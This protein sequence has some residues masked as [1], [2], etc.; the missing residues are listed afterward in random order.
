MLERFGLE[1]KILAINADN[2]SSNK[3]QTEA[4]EK[5]KNSFNI[6]NRVRCF[7]HTI[8]LACKA[9]L[10]P[11]TA[12]TIT[13]DDDDDD[14]SSDGLPDLEDVSNDEDEDEEDSGEGFD[15]EGDCGLDELTQ[16]SEDKQRK[17]LDETAAVKQSL[18]KVSQPIYAI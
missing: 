14:T 7:N 15:H 3:T 6:V 10:H 2:A 1:N 8:Q 4:L 5:K 9:I 12:G 11:F 13:A 18:T 16:L 17:F